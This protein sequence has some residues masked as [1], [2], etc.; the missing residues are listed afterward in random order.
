MEKKANQQYQLIPRQ[1]WPISTESFLRKR[2]W[3]LSIKK[4]FT[5]ELPFCAYLDIK[6]QNIS[7]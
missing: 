1:N 6:L 2:V 5:T 4:S 7:S 3:E